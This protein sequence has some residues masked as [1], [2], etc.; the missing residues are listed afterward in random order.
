M[1]FKGQMEKLKKDQLAHDLNNALIIIQRMSKFAINSVKKIN[2]SLS[3]ND[4]Q[5]QLNLLVK[6]LRNINIQSNQIKELC[7]KIIEN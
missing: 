3:E 2:C 1:N 6:C 4:D 5:L 7:Q